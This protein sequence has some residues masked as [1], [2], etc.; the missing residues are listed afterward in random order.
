MASNI[1]NRVFLRFI[2]HVE[3][4]YNST[5]T[6]LY[7]DEGFSELLGL[8][9]DLIALYEAWGKPEKANEWQ[10][11]LAQIEDFEE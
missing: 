9:N 6:R 7:E 10:I 11:E 4:I 1:Y 5:N 8:M 3:M 2:I